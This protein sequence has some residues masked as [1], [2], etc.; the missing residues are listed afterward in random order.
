MGYKLRKLRKPESKNDF[1]AAS[2][3]VPMEMAQ[4]LPDDIQFEPELTDE[5]L[6]YRP[7]RSAISAGVERPAW[8]TN[9]NGEAT[10]KP[11]PATAAKSK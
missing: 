9:G 5:G 2:L 1:D 3:A 10:S 4:I 11:K 7:V 8:L 6:L